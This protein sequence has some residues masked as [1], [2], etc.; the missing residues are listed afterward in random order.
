MRN[1]QQIDVPAP[2]LDCSVFA[3]C[4]SVD[5]VKSEKGKSQGQKLSFNSK[6]FQ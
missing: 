5:I 6:L 3:D 4:A 2:V 1:W